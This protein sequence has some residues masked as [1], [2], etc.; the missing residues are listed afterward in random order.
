MQFFGSKANKHIYEAKYICDQNW[1]KFPS[2]VF[3]I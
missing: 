2:L 3:E 1:A